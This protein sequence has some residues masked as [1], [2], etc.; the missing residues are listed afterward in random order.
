M[1]PALTALRAA[2]TGLHQALHHHRLLA[3]LSRDDLTEADYRR[4]LLGLFG[5]HCRAWQAVAPFHQLEALLT[6]SPTWLAQDLAALGVE[7]RHLPLPPPLTADSAEAALGILYVKEG[8]L[9]GGRHLAKAVQRQLGPTTPCRHFH[10]LGN[11]TGGHWQAVIQALTQVPVAAQ[12]V[13][14]TAASTGFSHLGGWLDQLEAAPSAP[15]A[16]QL[17]RT[18]G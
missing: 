13:L 6:P 5:F 8:S 14:C 10:G 4:A 18:G 17:T 16:W 2:T 15:A 7:P 1:S 11:A 12:T 3:P 9:L